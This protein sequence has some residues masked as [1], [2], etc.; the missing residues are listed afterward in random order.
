M[1]LTGDDKIRFCDACHKPVFHCDT[2]QEAQLHAW[3]GECV[4][5]DSRLPRTPGDLRTGEQRMVLGRLAL[6]LRI[7]PQRQGETVTIRSGAFAGTQG[8]V[9]R[10][11]D[12]RQRVRV[13][14]ERDGRP[15]TLDLNVSDV[16]F[17]SDSE[18]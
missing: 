11:D 6:P 1:Q 12:G 8:E 17:L 16:D 4:A 14:V 9:E 15:M 7:R 2:V 3:D 13:R 10:I 18:I 5:I